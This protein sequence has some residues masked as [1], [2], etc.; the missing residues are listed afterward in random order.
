MQASVPGSTEQA[1]PTATPKLRSSEIINA[2]SDEQKESTGSDESERGPP[3]SAGLLASCAGIEA[4]TGAAGIELCGPG[5][6][7]DLKRAV[8]SALLW[9]SGLEASGELG[10]VLEPAT[11]LKEIRGFNFLA[12]AIFLANG[13]GFEEGGGASGFS[14]GRGDGTVTAS[15][16]SGGFSSKEGTF[17]KPTAL[18][19]FARS[20]RTT[21]TSPEG[22]PGTIGKRG[23]LE[24]GP[25]LLLML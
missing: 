11:G 22:A 16:T 6:Q 8:S 14:P 17:P 10:G 4:S 21:G 3:L 25:S 13:S 5:P 7:L 24:G 19:T 1:S 9:S 23:F 15:V 2:I 20:T 12:K 18:I